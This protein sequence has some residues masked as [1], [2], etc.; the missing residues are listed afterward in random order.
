MKTLL[1][2]LTLMVQGVV[3]TPP[4]PTG[5][6]EGLVLDAEKKPIAGA[7]VRAFWSP[8]P[9]VL[10]PDQVPR[11]VS[12]SDGRFVIRDLS[13]GGYTLSVA[14]VGFV[15]YEGSVDDGGKVIVVA[16]GESSQGITVRLIRDGIVSGRITA[17]NG[18][19]L[20][21]MEV[22]ALKKTFDANGWP[23]ITSAG[24]RAVTD[25]RGEF[26]ISGLPPGRYFVR[27]ES[28]L[29]GVSLSE[30]RRAAFEGRAAPAKPTP[31]VFASIYYPGA[32]DI[33][34][35]TPLD[36]QLGLEVRNINIV[37][38]QLQ[39]YTIRG[40]ISDPGGTNPPDRVSV[41]VLPKTDW[42][43]GTTM[44]IA[45]PAYDPSAKLIS[46]YR[47]D[48]T[49][50]LEG[51]APGV[52]WIR[53]QI[54]ARLSAEQSA[55]ISTPGAD[56]T[57]LP[58]PLRGA[59]L[60]TVVDSNVENVDVTIVRDL[61]L[62]G[63]ITVETQAEPS[64]IDFSSIRV[65]LKGVEPS[66]LGLALGILNMAADG[67]FTIRN[68]WPAE[69]FVTVSGLPPAYYIVAGRLGN[70]DALGKAISL[71]SQPVESLAITVAK[72]TEV[73]G[74]VTDAASMAIPNQ[75]VVLIPD[76]V[77]SRPDLYKTAITDAGGRFV[78]HG[79]A[80]GRY[81]AY[82]WKAIEPYRYFDFQFVSAFEDKGSAIDVV[83]PSVSSVAVKLIQE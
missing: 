43:S 80:P 22:R 35:A 62:N 6:I 72:G 83:G 69:Y 65:Q 36:L 51:V 81:R 45:G 32:A 31:G 8:L 79:V 70:R 30:E 9:L 46:A 47:P 78:L 21:G 41:G 24:E 42:V 23:T 34:R 15:R 12:A 29:S 1:L 14:A 20:L 67:K 56:A 38:P 44:S 49:Y 19:P 28:Q 57:K 58:A 39:I 53:A 5:S 61:T 54:Q 37:L 11:A 7:E 64:P 63:S 59:T 66:R 3:P 60:V 55:F 77:V 82:A 52:Y 33:E 74:M 18:S 4:G 76:S 71:T 16:P 26:R 68:L 50:E 48:G 73:T 2:A 40:A 75:Q 27:A 13:A 10:R 17:T 25:D